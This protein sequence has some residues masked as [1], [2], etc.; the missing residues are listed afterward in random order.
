MEVEGD[1]NCEYFVRIGNKT[2]KYASYV[3]NQY[4][5]AKKLRSRRLEL[6][7]EER[8]EREREQKKRREEDKQRRWDKRDPNREMTREQHE[9]LDRDEKEEMATRG[10]TEVK[11]GM[12]MAPMTAF[13]KPVAK[14]EQRE[15]QEEAKVAVSEADKNGVASTYPPCEATNKETKNK[16]NIVDEGEIGAKENAFVFGKGREVYLRLAFVDKEEIDT[17]KKTSAMA[18]IRVKGIIGPVEVEQMVDENVAKLNVEGFGST[19]VDH[20]KRMAGKQVTQSQFRELKKALVEAHGEVHLK[21]LTL[22]NRDDGEN[23]SWTP[24]Q[25]EKIVEAVE[26]ARKILEKEE[27]KTG[28]FSKAAKLLN[29]AYNGQ[30]N[31]LGRMSKK[32]VRYVYNNRDAICNATGSRVKRGR[33]CMLSEECLDTLKAFANEA[34]R[35]TTQRPTWSY[36]KQNFE[37]I[38]RECNEEASF[39]EKC[40]NPSRYL[41]SLIPKRSGKENERN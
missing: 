40:A 1:I 18:C 22:Q 10:R 12:G 9:Q 8:E 30:Y 21:Y 6:T 37:R 14:E 31:P 15:R 5:D 24:E 27:K 39:A 38:I 11:R 36:F 19:L 28:H 26:K 25:V 4:R 32:K 13:F 3:R 33:P 2:I 20:T 23:T 41:R 29:D 7:E 17:M 35:D 16:E 34:V